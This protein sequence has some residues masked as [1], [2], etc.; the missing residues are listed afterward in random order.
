MQ[1][2]WYYVTGHY[3]IECPKI[4]AQSMDGLTADITLAG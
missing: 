4:N 3:L 1:Q 2:F